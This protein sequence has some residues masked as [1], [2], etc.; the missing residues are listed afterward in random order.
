MKAAFERL[1]GATRFDPDDRQDQI[2]EAA[3][4]AVID[5]AISTGCTF[6][7]ID[8]ED[9]PSLLGGLMVG[10]VQVAQSVASSGRGMTADEIDAAIRASI[11]QIAPW[12]VD[13]A[14][15]AQGREPLGHD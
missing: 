15:S 10:I 7:V 2:G 8:G 4:K 1:Y 14:R 13:M 5:S 12:S 3:R 9:M 11:I 6:G